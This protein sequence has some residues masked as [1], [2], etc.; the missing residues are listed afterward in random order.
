[1]QNRAEIS[2]VFSLPLRAISAV[3]F[4]GHAQPVK[5]LFA[6]LHNGYYRNLDSVVEELARRGHQVHLGAERE[7]SSFGGQ[8][9]VDRLTTA[10][11]NVTCGRTAVRDPESLF[12]PAKIRFAIDYLRYLDP[13]YSASSGLPLR[14]RER[15]PAGM[16]RLSKSLPLAWRPIRHLVN[17]ALDAVD[18]AVPPSPDIERFL[19]LQRPDLIVI[20]PLIGLVASSQ[21][22][23]LR[24][25]LR[26]GVATAVMVWS[27]DHLSSKA[28]IRDIP[29][30]LLVWNDVQKREAITMHGVAE[31][32]IV[33]TGAQ[34]YDRWFGRLPT[35]SRAEFVRHAGLHDD[36]PFV[37]WTCSALLPGTP[38]EPGI[39]LR[40][41]S[42]L[43]RSS[44]PRVRDIPILLRPH[45]SRTADWVGG[46]WRSVGN[47]V[48]FGGPPIDD[49]GRE[50]YFES[51][52]YSAAVVGITTSAFLEAAVVGRPVMSF[53]ADDLVAEHEA[54][55]HF[56]YLADAERGLLTMANSLDE[57]ERHLASVL[58]GPPPDMLRRQER[59]VGDF[60]RPRGLNVSAT[61]V[62]ADS[63]ERLPNTPRIGSSAV[64]SAFGRLAWLQLQRLERDPRW[65]HL[66]LDEREIVRESRVM[67]KARLKEQ[68]LSRK[69]AAKQMALARKRAAKS[70]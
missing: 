9:I 8:P 48:M 7:D 65:R 60:I 69:R 24:S 45:P 29:D 51:L 14:A 2:A 20:T 53:Y 44:N 37:L 22:D 38:P 58:T 67:T 40:W 13:A 42:H 33:V 32:R 1:V 55:L 17:Q 31:T 25:A 54:S 23:L 49:Q 34:C 64:P 30:A 11:P 46:E 50:D 5:I 35:R 39:F 12:L 47:V 3:V 70:R 63:L 16:L 36:R 19:D 18:R 52:H 66:I 15:T 4:A 10:Y 6:A 57:H 62:V 21:I 26:R 68:E 27:W 43:R 61:S 59:F 41:A 56:Q 28:I